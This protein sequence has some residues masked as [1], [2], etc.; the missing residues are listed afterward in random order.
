MCTDFKNYFFMNFEIQ[1]NG[2]GREYR[3]KYIADQ[4]TLAVMTYRHPTIRS[5]IL[6][7]KGIVESSSTPKEIIEA[8]C[9]RYFSNF[10]GRRQ[11]SHKLMQYSYK[12]PIIISEHLML[13]AFPTKSILNAE[14]N[15]F[16]ANNMVSVDK[17]N[18]K[19]PTIIFEPGITL[20]IDESFHTLSYQFMKSLALT[21]LYQSLLKK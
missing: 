10:E 20:T 4:D 8:T 14:N 17:N 13:V 2:E 21:Y 11:A 7:K 6:T 5:I 12:A 9:I 15:W 18:G 19:D 1:N 3:E 16:F